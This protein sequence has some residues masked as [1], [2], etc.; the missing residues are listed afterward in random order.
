MWIYSF[1]SETYNFILYSSPRIGAKK[2]KKGFWSE[3]KTCQLKETSATKTPFF[4]FFSFL[5]F[6]FF[7]FFNSGAPRN[8]ACHAPVKIQ[9]HYFKADVEWCSCQGDFMLMQ[10]LRLLSAVVLAATYLTRIFV[11]LEFFFP[12]RVFKKMI[13]AREKRKRTI[14]N[15]NQTNTGF[16]CCNQR[17]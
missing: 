11:A 5:S 4:F 12:Q 8:S 14:A 16:V 13:T 6:D 9:T 15:Y 17:P 10:S 7:F 1:K 3:K 2:R